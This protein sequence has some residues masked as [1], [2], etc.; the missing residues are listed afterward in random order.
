MTMAQLRM[1]RDVVQ[2]TRLK[3]IDGMLQAL[4]A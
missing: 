3:M 2:P 4:R 1:E